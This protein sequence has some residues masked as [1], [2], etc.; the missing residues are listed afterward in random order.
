M[1]GSAQTPL[2]SISFDDSAAE[3]DVTGAGDAMHSYEAGLPNP[4]CTIE[5]VGATATAI[6]A[7]GALDI[8]WFDGGTTDITDV[9]CTAVSI[10]GSLDGPITSSITCRPGNGIGTGS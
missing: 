9:V 8:N 3:V 1:F 4:S 7:N 6:A 10:N 5:V 2:I